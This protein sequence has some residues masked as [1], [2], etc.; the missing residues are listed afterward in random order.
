MLADFALYTPLQVSAD[1]WNTHWAGDPMFLALYDG[2][3][4]GCA[5]LDRDTG[6]P[7]RGEK[8]LTAV[9][10]DWRGHGIASHLKRRALQWAANGLREIYTW[11]QAGYSSMLP[12]SQTGNI[13]DTG[14]AE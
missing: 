2:D 9:S 8:A 14:G 13:G 5:G 1:Q 10:R 6:Q 7:E 11:T 3:V 4:I 12:S